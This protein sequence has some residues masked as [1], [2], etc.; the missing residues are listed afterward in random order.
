MNIDLDTVFNMI[1]A[2]L[3]KDL[4]DPYIYKPYAHALYK[5]WRVV[6]VQE[7]PKGKE[8]EVMNE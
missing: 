5:V 4:E 3:G 7:R 8:I 2:Q 1:R 6:D